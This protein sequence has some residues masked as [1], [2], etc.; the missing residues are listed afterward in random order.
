VRGPQIYLRNRPEVTSS[1]SGWRLGEFSI[2]VST[3]DITP[4][5]GIP[6][7]GYARYR[8]ASSVQSNLKV[9]CLYLEQGNKS[10]LIATADAFV[11]PN[12]T[13]RRLRLRIAEEL[14]IS[15]NGILVAASHTHSAPDTLGFASRHNRQAA[16]KYLMTLE[17]SIVEAA[18]SARAK[19]FDARAYSATGKALIGFNRVNWSFKQPGY[20]ALVRTGLIGHVSRALAILLDITNF[21]STDGQEITGP[22]DPQLRIIWFEGDKGRGAAILN[23]ACHPT[24][25]GPKSQVISGDFPSAM[26]QKVEKEFGEGFVGLFVNGA[27]GNVNP[28]TRKGYRYQGTTSDVD[29][30]GRMLADEALRAIK[31]G[32]VPLKADLEMKD[33]LVRFNGGRELG[34]QL[35]RIG[36]LALVAVPGELFVETGL[37]LARQIEGRIMVIG[38]ANGY[39]GYLPPEGAFDL[40]SRE[41]ERAWWNLAERGAAEKIMSS[42]KAMMN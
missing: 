4:E 20:R 39:V 23:Y 26:T 30:L 13:F 38:Y 21:P 27:A 29:R 34:I 16:S 8:P 9:K 18:K 35:I 37:E 33:C 11:I 31:G 41:T 2:G 10:G 15:E 12:P 36:D 19:R 24:V 1:R 3:L 22:I 5:L 28:I 32:S 14:S 40:R 7:G 17:N 25:L 42:I 6:L